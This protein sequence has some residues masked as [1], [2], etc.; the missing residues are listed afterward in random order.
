MTQAQDVLLIDAGNTHVKLCRVQNGKLGKV[1]RCTIEKLSEQ[2]TDMHASELQ[3]ICTSVLSE[4]D[5]QRQFKHLYPIQIYA[6][7]TALPVDVN[8]SPRNS[9]GM[10][11]LCNASAIHKLKQ[12]QVAVSIDIGTCV[13]FDVVEENTFVGGSISPGIELRF[14]A[15]HEFTGKLPL[16]TEKKQIHL[17]GQNTSESMLSGVMNGIQSEIEGMI[18]RYR[19]KYPSISFYVTGGDAKYFDFEGKNDIFAP[20]NLT[21]EGLYT[22]Y[23]HNAI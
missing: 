11:R 21:L 9:I 13:K 10:D 2:I 12:T 22:I 5:N 1:S 7:E 4:E 17:I 18:M 19:N 16:L 23:L 15:M 8:Y 6:P 14:R 3:K 20:E